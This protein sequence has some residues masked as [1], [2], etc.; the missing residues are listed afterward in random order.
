[1]I[2]SRSE[3]LV[4]STREIEPA[5]IALDALAQ[6]HRTPAFVWDEP[7]SGFICA[8]FGRAWEHVSAPGQDRIAVAAEA[9]ESLFARLDALGDAAAPRPRLVGG[10][11]FA[12]SDA[13]LAP[14][15]ANRWDDFPAG[16]LVLP[17]FTYTLQDGRAWLTAVATAGRDAM[18]GLE[19]AIDAA[20]AGL[21]PF[22]SR[23]TLRSIDG[24]GPPDPN[25]EEAFRGLVKQAVAE[26]ESGKLAKV[27]AARSAHVG[28]ASD[29]WRILGALRRRYP[30]CVIYGVF[31][32]DSV[33]VGASPELLVELHDGRVSSSALAGTV[34]RGVDVF[35]DAR[36]E[37]RLRHDPKELAEHQYVVQGLRNAL[38]GVG[39]V[40][41]PPQ[42]LDI[43]KLAN[44]Q[45]LAS[46]VTGTAPRGTGILDLVDAVHPT[47][48]VAGLPRSA[49]LDWLA[50]HEGLDRGWYAGPIG[51][52][53]SSLDGTF[54]VALRCALLRGDRARV[55]AGAGIV[56]GSRPERELAE[57]TA[58]LRA[59]LDA[60]RVR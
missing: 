42:Q 27:V 55:F 15:S 28:G 8:G 53:D 5:L 19:R 52:V 59:M 7:D 26:V 36:L 10:F 21:Q 23:R 34:T 58:K 31:R 56:A 2:D 24:P 30:S 11:S 44:V 47:P 18:P 45:H 12:P 48:A 1:M 35:A 22:A 17:R 4:A 29:P 43:V 16:S 50:E 6:G 49:A 41:D 40:I 57:T 13:V 54:R 46:P 9:A 60:L 25:G 37:D 32:N 39:V 20:I 33:F 51:F 3:T 14:P 38:H